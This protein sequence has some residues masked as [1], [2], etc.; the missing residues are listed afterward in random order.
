MTVQGPV[1]KEQPDVLSHRGQQLAQP[2]YAKFWAPL[3]RKRHRKEYRPLRPSESSNPTQHAKGRTGDCPG[4]RKETATR[5]NVTQG[6]WNVLGSTGPGVE[7]F[8]GALQQGYGTCEIDRVWGKLLRWWTARELRRGEPRA[9][10]RRMLRNSKR[11][12]EGAC[13]KPQKRRCWYGRTCLRK[14]TCPFRHLD[15]PYDHAEGEGGTHTTE[16]GGFQH[17]VHVVQG[18]TQELG[19]PA[20]RHGGSRRAEDGGDA[21]VTSQLRRMPSTAGCGAGRR[22]RK[23]EPRPKGR[24]V[25]GNTKRG[26][27][28]AVTGEQGSGSPPERVPTQEHPGT[29]QG[30]LDHTCTGEETETGPRGDPSLDPETASL[31]MASTVD[32]LLA[33][34]GFG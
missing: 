21:R 23:A 17:P 6:V 16:T 4:P 27:Y 25:E 31:S 20:G 9:W 19:A 1:K 32:D 15:D 26:A 5:R 30:P 24:L 13:E 11:T 34:R 10:F 28:C 8:R 14:A 3:T 29:G 7:G 33:C 18:R 2:E 12:G 22:A